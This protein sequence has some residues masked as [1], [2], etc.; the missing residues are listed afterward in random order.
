M[1]KTSNLVVVAFF[2]TGV[3]AGIAGASAEPATTPSDKGMMQDGM[4]QGG[5]MMPMMQQMSKM[6]ENCNK[7]MQTMMDR[8]NTDGPGGQASDKRG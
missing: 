5:G 4:M 3:I 7:M 6:T 2:G 1:F 8:Q